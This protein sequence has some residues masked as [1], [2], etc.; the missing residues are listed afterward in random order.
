MKLA[1][2]TFLVLTL[3]VTLAM[4]QATNELA[5]VS[6]E[7]GAVLLEGIDVEAQRQTGGPP[8]FEQQQQR[9]L[10]RP[11]AETVISV[12]E[13]DPGV[14]SAV[15]DILADVPGVYA[16]P[17]NANS[18][19]MISIRGSDAAQNGPRG[20]RGVRTYL[21][22]MPIGRTEAG[23]TSQLIDLGAADYVEIYRGANSLRY[24]SMV[25]GGAINLVS[26]TGLNMPGLRVGASAGS[27]GYENELA[28]YGQ[29]Y[30]GYDAFITGALSKNDGYQ[31]HNRQRTQK[32][33]ANI[34]WRPTASIENRMY[35]GIGEDLQ[36]LAGSIPL[37]Q[38][39]DLRRAEGFGSTRTD[40]S[41]YNYRANFN[42]QRYANRTTIAM[43]D[44]SLEIVGYYLN[45]IFDHL[46]VKNSGIVDN[47]WWDY[48]LSTRFE[49]RASLFSLPAEFVAGLRYNLETGDFN[50]WRH[51]DNGVTKARN[52]GKWDFKSPMWES[53]AETAVEV[54]PRVR[55]FVGV[56]GLYL[57]RDLT[58]RYDGPATIAA[59]A[60][61]P[62]RSAGRQEYERHFAAINPKVGVNWEWQRQHYLFANVAKSTEVPT[63]A[64]LSNILSAQASSGR[65]L[66]S[67]GMQ[68]AWTY[69]IGT[70]GGWVRFQY[71]VTA[72]HMDLRDELLTRCADEIPAVV[73]STSTNQIAFNAKKTTHD[74]LE[75]GLRSVPAKEV[76]F[77]DDRIT[78]NA[79]WTYLDARFN[80]DERFGFARLP[81][82]P[83][84]TF[85]S[86]LGWR[87]DNGI[88][89]S[90]NVRFMSERQ[91]TFDNS[92]GALFIVPETA[93]YG[94]KLGWQPDDKAWSI[95]G[96]IRNITDTAYVGDV[97]GLS[98]YRATTT[99]TITVSP[100][101]GRAFYFGGHILF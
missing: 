57:E 70:R 11:G 24:G 100:G 1:S 27:F 90:T 45:T 8:S 98:T 93:I 6:K 34:G 43:G 7:G 31:V 17:R 64:D 49:Q 4:A 12:T 79:S 40:P 60:T 88:F 99:G 101:D 26:K 69:E 47:E 65:S 95:W 5:Q 91:S 71:D 87:H 77:P 72:Y 63:G 46:P 29:S 61:Q 48:G 56:Q 28:E 10:K 41:G 18:Q 86:E 73:C 75:I 74:G 36:E 25:T 78:L 84:H 52:V 21:D 37:N 35:F 58:D 62:G 59:S 3:P 44:S 81:V 15:R 67:P 39:R 33:S 32:I 51:A 55:T 97:S 30:G 96:E 83:E 14:R 66:S 13:Q 82:L 76:F 2:A 20:G 9:F 94:A 22:G 80:K 23:F 92:G 89:L 53:Y 19:G 42:Y 50:R 38:L 16:P 54:L 85:F 68:R